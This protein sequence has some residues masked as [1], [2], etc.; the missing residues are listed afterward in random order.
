MAE[1]PGF[2]PGVE[3]PLQLLSRQLPSAARPP[4]R[5]FSTTFKQFEPFKR[6]KLLFCM[7]ERE[8]FE[9][10]ELSLNGFQDRRLKPLGHLSGTISMDDGCTFAPITGKLDATPYALRPTSLVPRPSSLAILS[11]PLIYFLSAS[12]M[13]TLP[14]GC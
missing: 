9:P 7:A 6:F 14:S 3:F 13:I 4:L 8:G 10:P 5:V 2:E 1:R 12:G 11:A